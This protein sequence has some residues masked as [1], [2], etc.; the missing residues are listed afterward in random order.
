VSNNNLFVAVKL[1]REQ[2][3]ALIS[4]RDSALEEINPGWILCKTCNSWVVSPT[5]QPHG[6]YT[7]WREQDWAKAK[8]L[9]PVACATAV[10]RLAVLD[11]FLEKY[12]DLK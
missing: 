6:H 9:Q 7:G 4:I 12:K 1:L 8:G 10:R 11:E 3:E 5:P 2:R